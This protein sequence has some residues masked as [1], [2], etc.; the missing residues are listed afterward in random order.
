[1]LLHVTINKINRFVN[2]ISIDTV[3]FTFLFD[4]EILL[5]EEKKYDI[6]HLGE[7]RK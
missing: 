4:Y 3:W 6:F 7:Q 1:M 2:I 5:S